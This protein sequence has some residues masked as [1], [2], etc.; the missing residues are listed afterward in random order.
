MWLE[1]L[2]IIIFGLWAF[3]EFRSF[4][5]KNTKLN[6]DDNDTDIQRILEIQ[7]AI[8][9]QQILEVQKQEE[10]QKIEAQRQLELK[11]YDDA[12]KRSEA[13]RAEEA[14][15][16]AEVERQLEKE[17]EE[18][19][20]LEK[21]KRMWRDAAFLKLCQS[22]NAMKVEGALIYDEIANAKRDDNWT[23]LMLA[24]RS[25]YIDIVKLLLKHKA[26]VN[27][28]SNDGITALMGRQE[29]AI[30]K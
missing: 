1:S 24:T 4:F 27:A 28:T 10:A 21:Q 6:R 8:K 14:K 15:R 3:S 26:N 9:L 18:R 29:K 11:R 16:R 12:L 5:A 13:Q 23:A 25:G 19:I 20:K 17:R 22:G 30:K 7:K 2:I